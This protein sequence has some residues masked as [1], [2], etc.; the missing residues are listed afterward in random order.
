MLPPL[1]GPHILKILG[2]PGP[3]PDLGFLADDGGYS[4][5]TP[6]LLIK[7]LYVLFLNFQV[8]P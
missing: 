8:L 7:Q 5:L 3:L 6:L 4:S 2:V 1:S